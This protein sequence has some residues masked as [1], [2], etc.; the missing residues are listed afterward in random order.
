MNFYQPLS[1]YSLGVQLIYS[2]CCFEGPTLAFQ[3]VFATGNHLL[4]PLPLLHQIP[5]PQIPN[6]QSD[7]LLKTEVLSSDLIRK[8][9]VQGADYGKQNL[10]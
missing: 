5:I 3:L 6:F 4:S 2:I 1:V 10:P 8:F 7:N 9:D